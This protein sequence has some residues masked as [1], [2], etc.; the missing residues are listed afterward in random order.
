MNEMGMGPSPDMMTDQEKQGLEEMK[1]DRNTP[2]ES[3]A[4]TMHAFAN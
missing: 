3:D 1:Q 2:L 4:D